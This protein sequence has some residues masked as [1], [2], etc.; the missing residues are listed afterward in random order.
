MQSFESLRNQPLVTALVPSYNHGRFLRDRIDSILAQTYR[1]FELIVIDDCSQDNSDEIILRLKNEYDFI[2]IKNERNSGTPFSAWEKIA[3]LARGKYIWICESDDV[4]EPEF[5]NTAV[6]RLEYNSNAVLFY[7]NSKIINDIGEYIGHTDTYFEDF[8][9]D[10]RWKYDFS[11]NG[12]EELV[13]YQVRGQTV[14][15]MSS[16]LILTTIF[17]RAFNPFL[18]RF[19]LTGDWLFIGNIMYYG[20][21]EFSCA[22]LNRFR[23]H[24]VTSRERVKSACSQAEF[25]LTKYCLYRLS[26][27]PLSK[28]ASFMSS[29]VV[30]F[31]YESA[32]WWDVV[33]SL[34]RISLLKT[35]SF[36]FLFLF[37]ATNHITDLNRFKQ[38]Y[39]DAK[40][41]RIENA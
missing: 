32:S 21:I 35:I 6:Q 31:L 26:G 24:Q 30:R 33:K 17:K 22:A 36:G 18:K 40:K 28:F 7:S 16:A 39:K 27:L 2:Y 11:A 4:A 12:F 29:D 8:W 19:Q 9:K 25:I 14:P 3:E 38:L 5:L 41:W 37:S 34:L 23:K 10:S 13:K 20:D 15:N 1:N